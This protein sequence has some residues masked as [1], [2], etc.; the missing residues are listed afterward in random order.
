MPLLDVV[1]AAGADPNTRNYEGQPLSFSTSITRPKLEVL[2]R[3]GADFTAPDTR[4]DRAGWTAAMFAAQISQWDLVLF[5][6]D[7]GVCADHVVP[8][9]TSL[10]TI[11]AKKKREGANPDSLASI[12]RRM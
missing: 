5:F 4:T 2:A 12:M 11:L 3:H 6:L 1:L 8:D 7:H 9:G 10:R